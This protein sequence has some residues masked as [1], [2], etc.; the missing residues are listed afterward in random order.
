M[1]IPLKGAIIEDVERGAEFSFFGTLKYQILVSNFSFR[2]DGINISRA[3]F[4][5][6][7]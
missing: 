6:K 2:Q 4:V 1:N 7:N 5:M 3:F